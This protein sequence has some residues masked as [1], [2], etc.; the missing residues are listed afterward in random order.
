M[1]QIPKPRNPDFTDILFL[2][3]SFPIY[4]GLPAPNKRNIPFRLG[5]NTEKLSEIYY[6]KGRK[7]SISNG[8]ETLKV[9]L[10]LY[11][12]LSSF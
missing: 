5:T 2:I 4:K 6:V 12:L 3:N 11:V 7:A 10:Q 1:P 8:P 9:I